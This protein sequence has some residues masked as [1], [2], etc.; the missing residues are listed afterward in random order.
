MRW[1]L[2]NRRSAAADGRSASLIANTGAMLA[3][4][5]DAVVESQLYVAP[6]AVANV[7]GQ[8]AQFALIVVLIA[9]HSS[10]VVLTVPAVLCEVVIIWWKRRGLR[11]RLAIKYTPDWSTWLT[12]L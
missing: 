11:S 5:I 2:K 10:L 6:I 4:R 12:L 9:A 3:S 1:P 8:A 7:L